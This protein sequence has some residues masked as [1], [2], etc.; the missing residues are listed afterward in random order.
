M[1][2]IA[3]FS[4]LHKIPPALHK[5]MNLS[6]KTSK[7]YVTSIDEDKRVSLLAM[8]P[9]HLRLLVVKSMYQGAVDNIFFFSGRDPV[10]LTLVV[11]R[12]YP[13]KIDRGTA[14]YSEGDHAEEMYFIVKGQVNC[15][16]AQGF[17]VFNCLI[18][19]S[20]FGEIE[21]LEK[22]TRRFGT[23]A[24]LNCEFLVMAAHVIPI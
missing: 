20:H 22:C 2:V 21:L 3:T 19:G 18:E 6:I 8:I 9:K 5:E 13:V 7:H 1:N 11:P 10:F 16:I 24:Q 17:T 12:L 14:I 23:V 15:M 4:E